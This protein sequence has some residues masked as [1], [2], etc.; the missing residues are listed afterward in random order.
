MKFSY[1]F[2][3]NSGDQST[4]E[5]DFSGWT[6]RK[7]GRSYVELTSFHPNA[8]NGDF[9]NPIRFDKGGLVL[10]EDYG[11]GVFHRLAM[12][13]THQALNQSEKVDQV[14]FEVDGEE[15]ITVPTV[16]KKNFAYPFPKTFF[17]FDDQNNKAGF[18]LTHPIAYAKSFRIITR[19]PGSEQFKSDDVWNQ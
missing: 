19:W 4:W 17:R 18:Q 1:I 11:A 10:F 7:L 6:K 3:E 2:K 15:L 8:V 16:W 5:F 13:H 14:S 9:Y 12:L